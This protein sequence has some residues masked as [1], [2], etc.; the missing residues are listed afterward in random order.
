MFIKF[1]GSLY[2]TGCLSCIRVKFSDVQLMVPSSK[3]PLCTLHYSSSEL[4]AYAYG[5]I[6]HGFL[7]KW[8]CVDASEDVIAKLLE[9]KED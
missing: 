7:G 5:R 2:N 3:A 8:G 1:G 6:I 4:A 9:D